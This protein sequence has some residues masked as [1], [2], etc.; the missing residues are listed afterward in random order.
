MSKLDGKT[1]HCNDYSYLN[2]FIDDLDYL[3]PLIRDNPSRFHGYNLFT[4]LDLRTGYWQLRCAEKYRHM[5]AFSTFIDKFEYCKVPMGL[6]TSPRLFQH[7][8]HKI[9][10]QD[11]ILL[12]ARSFNDAVASLRQTFECIR[13]HR[14]KLK[15]EKCKFFR[16][17]VKYLILQIN[18]KQLIPPQN[19]LDQ[20]RSFIPNYS[21]LTGSLYH[22]QS[23]KNHKH[24]KFVNEWEAIHQKAFDDLKAALTA[25]G[26]VLHQ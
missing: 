23:P 6:K 26:V 7:A 11:D 10:Y 18:N 3:P 12:K 21:Q 15:L 9:S 20:Y 13:S 17:E 14:L 4:V 19:K 24:K 1:R 2:K 8:M 16:E 25:D 22:L 5:T